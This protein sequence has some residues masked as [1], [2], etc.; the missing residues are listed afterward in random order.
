MPRAESGL[1]KLL[2]GAGLST[3]Q[4]RRHRRDRVRPDRIGVSM[5][6]QEVEI[7][8]NVY[9]ITAEAA[10]A[11]KQSLSAPPKAVVSGNLFEPT[12]PTITSGFQRYRSNRKQ[13]Q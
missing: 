9:V 5:S 1:S 10:E 8:E 12:G 7:P 11:Y 2:R 3:M 6:P 4:K 13:R